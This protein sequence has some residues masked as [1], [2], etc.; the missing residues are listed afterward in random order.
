MVGFPPTN[1]GQFAPFLRLDLGILYRESRGRGL[2]WRYGP[3]L[4]GYSRMCFML[5]CHNVEGR[6]RHLRRWR[7]SRP[8]YPVYS[9]KGHGDSSQ[10][11]STW[12]H[13]GLLIT[14][15]CTSL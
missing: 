12:I 5:P 1:N 7:P 10:L 15:H 6:M 14:I 13:Y 4:G 8:L 3:S 9:L 11:H 2:N